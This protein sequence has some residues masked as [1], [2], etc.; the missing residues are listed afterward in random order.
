M[1]GVGRTHRVDKGLRF[2]LLWRMP[3]TKTGESRGV[4]NYSFI[5]HE[6][7]I[8][9]AIS[10]KPLR[11]DPAFEAQGKR[12]GRKSKSSLRDWFL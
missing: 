1:E 11:C 6:G 12:E 2:F 8:Q 5:K 4:V 10:N 7:I 9:Q 3:T